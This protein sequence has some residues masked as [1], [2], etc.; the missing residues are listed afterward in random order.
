[1]KRHAAELKRFGV[2]S[3]TGNRVII[4]FARI[5]EAFC[6]KEPDVPQRI[7]NG[8]PLAQYDEMILT[9]LARRTRRASLRGYSGRAR[10]SLIKSTDLSDP[11]LNRRTARTETD[12]VRARQSFLYQ[13]CGAWSVGDPTFELVSI[14]GRETLM[15]YDGVVQRVTWDPRRERFWC[16]SKVWIDIEWFSFVRVFGSHLSSAAIKGYQQNRMKR[17][18]RTRSPT[19][20]SLPL[21]PA[22]KS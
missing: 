22:P 10:Q 15:T 12:L 18:V 4:S 13:V 14:T 5:K 19:Q 17:S 9:E 16:D 2:V 1:M 8:I 20:L 21:R 6:F 3:T 11:V 7:D